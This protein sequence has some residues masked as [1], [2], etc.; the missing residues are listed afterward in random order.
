MKVIMIAFDN[1]DGEECIPIGVYTL[2]GFK[3]HLQYSMNYIRSGPAHYCVKF[4][5]F[6]MERDK[7]LTSISNIE[8]GA[9]D[10]TYRI[11]YSANAKDRWIWRAGQEIN[12]EDLI[13]EV[14]KL[15]P[16]QEDVKMKQMETEL[17]TYKA[18]VDKLETQ[19]NYLGN[20]LKYMPDGKGAL[21]A[22]EHY[23]SLITK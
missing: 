15:L 7:N 21:E 16:D 10:C 4:M 22:K 8:W 17:A 19:I 18:H 2:E 20:H 14:E 3:K 11:S 5:V 23:L 1:D 12:Y 9:N 13:N 6:I